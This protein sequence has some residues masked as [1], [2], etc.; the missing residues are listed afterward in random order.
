MSTT[1]T[2][3]GYVCQCDICHRRGNAG[4][5]PDLASRGFISI[6]L[7]A[8]T[9]T[10]CEPFLDASHMNLVQQQDGITRFYARLGSPEGEIAPGSQSGVT[11]GA[12]TTNLPIS[13]LSGFTEGIGT[14]NPRGLGN[15][16]LW[17]ESAQT[18]WAV[19]IMGAFSSV[20]KTTPKE[21]LPPF[22]RRSCW[23]RLNEDD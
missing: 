16:E 17:S 4:P 2:P 23:E 9:C 11:M 1:L 14:Y 12:Q 10:T 19:E 7:N 8:H 15:L 13:V 5:S 20:Q 3:D 18:E 21:E 6:D 22:E